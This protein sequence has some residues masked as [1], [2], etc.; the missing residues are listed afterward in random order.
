MVNGTESSL[1]SVCEQRLA[2]AGGADQQDVRLLEL[3]LL[4]ARAALQVL[5]A[6]V[7][8]VDRDRELLLRLLLADDVVVE[9]RLDLGRLGE[10][11]L[12]LLLEQAVLGDDVEADVDALVADEDGRPGDELLDLALAL[13]AERAA[14]RVVT[15][16]FLRH[17]SSA[18]RLDPQRARRARLASTT[19]PRGTHS[20]TA[21]ARLSHHP[22]SGRPPLAP[23]DCNK[24]SAQDLRR[25]HHLVD[26]AVGDRLFGA[27]DLVALGVL[28]HLRSR[29][30][31]CA[32]ARISS[33]RPRSLSSSRAWISTSVAW[34]PMPEVQGWWMRMR[35]L[36]SAVRL[37]LA[38]A[39][40]STAA[41]EAAWP[42][43]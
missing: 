7:V 25:C 29:P 24:R 33:M 11:G 9:Q 18:P 43:Q 39:A 19:R 2:G 37:P 42:T 15:R 20:R 31:R 12:L 34:P 32:T 35:Q 36:G 13:V 6:P 16:L 41:I 28:V 38:P 23:A 30:C 21:G 3:D 4:V 5:D 17:L 26:E 40:S 1:A 14:E 22:S 10:L 8:V 27:Q